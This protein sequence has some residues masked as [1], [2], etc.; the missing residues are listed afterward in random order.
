MHS[1]R[2]LRTGLLSSVGKGLVDRAF[3]RASVSL[4]RRSLSSI[5]F[6]GRY[7]HPCRRRRRRNWRLRAKVNTE[8]L[9]S[10]FLSLFYSLPSSLL[11]PILVPPQLFTIFSPCVKL[12]ATLQSRDKKFRSF[13]LIK[14][15]LG[16]DFCAHNTRS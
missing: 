1:R 10:L 4:D 12:D 9:H 14:V 8:R 5:Y 13:A 6:S 3:Q 2:N 11:F 7:F 15:K 16:K